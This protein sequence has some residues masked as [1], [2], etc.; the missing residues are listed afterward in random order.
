MM[1]GGYEAEVGEGGNRLSTGQK[2]LISFARAILKNPAIF[3]LDEATS[4]VDTETEQLIQRAIT[5]VLTGRTSFIIAHRL[6]TVRDADRILV[7]RD[8]KITEDGT[9]AE[10]I[11]LRG[12]YYRLYTNQ[13]QD[14]RSMAVLSG[15]SD[16]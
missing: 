13:F 15:L 4:S 16:Q 10:L 3:V 2:Q 8:G 11:A 9:H 1:K 14:E 7:I 5:R 6:S 12:Y